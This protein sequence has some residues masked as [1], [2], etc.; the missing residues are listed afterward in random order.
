[1]AAASPYLAAIPGAPFRIA[2]ASL[3]ALVALVAL[4]AAAR[5]GVPREWRLRSPDGRIAVHAELAGGGAPL[6]ATVRR[7]GA[8]VLT[9]TIGLATAGRCLP[10]G[11]RRGRA[12]RS[13]TFERYSTKAGKR[14]E[15][16]YLAR[17]LELRFKGRGA[18]V[19]VELSVS[20]DGFAHRVTL[21]GPARMRVLGECSSFIP[22]RGAEAWL[23]RFQL[24]YERQYSA[25]AAAA[26]PAAEYGFPA[27]L[28][29]GSTWLLLTESAIPLGQPATRL[30]VAPERPGVFAVARPHD[31]PGIQVVQTPWRVA[32]IGSASTIVESDLADDLGRRA[33]RRDWSWVRP[34]AVAWSWWADSGSPAR[35]ADQQHYV[36]FAARMGWRYVLVD[37]GWSP[38]WMPQLV[39]FARRRG[40]RVIV[41]SPWD[42][43]A[44]ARRR[45]ALLGLWSSWGVAGVKLDF[46]D[47]DSWARM[48]WYRGIAHAAALRHLVVDFHGSTAPRGFTRTWPNVLTTEGVVGAESYKGAAVQANP[49]QNTILPFTRNAV[50]PMD[51]TPVTFSAASRRTSDGHE[52]ALSVVFES[53]LQHFADSPAAYTARPIA[54]RWLERVPTAWD[55]TRLVGGYPGS[56]VTI[57]R[58]R[59]RRWF[60]GSISAGPRGV[61][62]LP[63]RFL[64]PGRRYSARIVED[65]P[66]GLR[67]LRVGRVTRRETL[68]LHR[69]DAGGYVVRFTPRPRR[70]GRH[71]GS[72]K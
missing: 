61:A 11:L 70:R 54:K 52:L 48:D 24:A 35:L 36:R 50:G 10:A 8:P 27:L 5:A 25:V 56:S 9:E 45:D 14:R 29:E 67:T 65:G 20:D 4:P 22:Q 46:M 28:R 64:Y 34:G 59:G 13:T 3:L 53:G 32:V 26:A 58:R 40:V 38:G 37:A 42:A 57:A 19:A 63:L 16:R 43:L 18:H 7:A 2:S 47:S 39:R 66:S 6:T 30:A 44:T 72:V 33:Q 23:Q 62:K 51:Y 68:R 60:A 31:R 12:R 49:A 1:V 69:A 41:W 15:H 55:D 71:T 21:T 17:R